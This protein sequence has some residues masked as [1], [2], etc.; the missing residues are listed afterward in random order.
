MTEPDI[1]RA[2]LVGRF[3]IWARSLKAC[4][5]VPYV[6]PEIRTWIEAAL[7]QIRE[8]AEEAIKR[9]KKARMAGKLGGRPRTD[10]PA[11]STIRARKSRAKK[12]KARKAKKEKE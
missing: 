5:G 7:E 10:N 4:Q 3:C 2:L 12:K 6:T 8:D 9:R 1:P 11:P